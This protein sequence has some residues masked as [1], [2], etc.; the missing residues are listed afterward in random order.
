MAELWTISQRVVFVNFH[1]KP[2]GGPSHLLVPNNKRCL[3]LDG[4]V[5]IKA[6]QRYVYKHEA[7][8]LHII[9]NLQ[10]KN[11]CSNCN[12]DWFQVPCGIAPVISGQCL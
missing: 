2:V 11:R 4:S 3:N 5:A 12:R 9:K 10:K 7:G 6:C 1:E 8:R